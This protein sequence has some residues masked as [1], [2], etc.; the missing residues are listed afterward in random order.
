MV[1][2][3]TPL[4]DPRALLASENLHG[5]ASA[6][7]RLLLP[8]GPSRE[9]QWNNYLAAVNAA[10]R[11]AS[12]QMALTVIDYE[13]V[14]LQLPEK[15]LHVTDGLHPVGKLLATVFL[16]L[17]LNEYTAAQHSSAANRV[18]R[19]RHTLNLPPRVKTRTSGTLQ[20]IT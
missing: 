1:T 20:L 5:R 8:A 16:D 9:L 4:R 7:D 13:A 12:R 15:H 17:L 6:H 10:L 19:S 11:H 18:Q 3:T 14:A 2:H